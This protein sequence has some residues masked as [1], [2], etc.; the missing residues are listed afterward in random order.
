M[1]R[2]RSVHPGL[3]TDEA[4]M[5]ASPHARMFLIG[6]WCE[7]DDQGVFEWKPLTL[8]ARLLPAD[9]VAVADLLTELSDLGFIRRFEVGEKAYGAVRNFRK[10]QRP[11]KPNAHFPLPDDQRSFV[12]LSDSAT[13]PLRDQYG[14]G[15]RKSPQMEDGGG[16]RDKKEEEKETN[17]ETPETGNG[18]AASRT[19][20]GG[21]RYFFQ[22]G[23]IRLNEADYRK[24]ERAFPNLNMQAELLA[25][26][27]WAEEQGKNWFHAV[28]A[29][30]AKRDRE[31]RLAV[32]Q[33]KANAIAAANAP[34]PKKPAYLGP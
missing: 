22:T 13:E 2:I 3:F 32:E 12:G 11:Q 1:S 21:G 7:C 5:A 31:A 17:P 4:F 14:T 20:R 9:A 25:L 10:Y 34:A 33:I 6:L 24:W 18:D 28:P 8:K 30:L 16:K 29:A 19:S 15:S 23:C 27:R 26:A